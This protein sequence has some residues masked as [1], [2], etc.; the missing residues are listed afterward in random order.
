M[1]FS[2]LIKEIEKMTSKRIET[3]NYVSLNLAGEEYK[4]L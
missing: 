3:Q 4:F 1:R 2:E